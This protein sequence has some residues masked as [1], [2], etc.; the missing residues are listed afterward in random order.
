[1]ATIN[2]TLTQTARDL[3]VSLGA[4]LAANPGLDPDNIRAGTELNEPGNRTISASENAKQMSRIL[5]LS[6]TGV[7][8]GPTFGE[9]QS[10]F[11][12]PPQA[13]HPTGQIQFGNTAAPAT[14]AGVAAT[15]TARASSM[16]DFFVQRYG[17]LSSDPVNPNILTPGGREIRHRPAVA[18]PGGRGGDPRNFGIQDRA[19]TPTRALSA[20][21]AFDDRL[22]GGR[23]GDPRELGLRDQSSLAATSGQSGSAADS[24]GFLFHVSSLTKSADPADRRRA[25]NISRLA[26]PDSPVYLEYHVA[27]T[28][29][30]IEDDNLSPTASEYI[31]DEIARREGQGETGPERLI[32]FGYI[33]HPRFAELWVHPD[34]LDAYSSYSAPGTSAY[35]ARGGSTYRPP[36][37]TSY[38]GGS[39]AIGLYNWHI[40]ITV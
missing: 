35:A 1:M 34:S 32:R 11:A 29:R 40:R 15:Q 14:P 16:A 19:P 26:A 10:G 22:S 20:G 18:Q 9:L 12:P 39:S 27:N 24:P 38:G 37:Q 28:L 8:G 36:G 33:P 2:K 17:I 31:W 23:G 6:S 25:E 7:A 30:E 3:G 21:P 5:S 4:L 13:P